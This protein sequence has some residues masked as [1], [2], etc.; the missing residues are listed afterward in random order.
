MAENEQSEGGRVVR[1][2]GNGGRPSVTADPWPA[3]GGPQSAAPAR[4]A[5]ARMKRTQAVEIPPTILRQL[6]LKHIARSPEDLLDL[7]NRAEVH[8]LDVSDKEV[9]LDSCAVTWEE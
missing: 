6:V 5:P 8:F 3:Q 7:I 1:L 4:V 9:P 2:E